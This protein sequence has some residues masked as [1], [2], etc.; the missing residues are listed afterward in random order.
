M[1]RPRLRLGFRRLTVALVAGARLVSLATCASASARAPVQVSP[2]LAQDDDFCLGCHGPATH[3]KDAPLTDRGP[4]RDS[5]HAAVKCSECHTSVTT[6]PHR[7]SLPPV[8]CTRCHSGNTKQASLKAQAGKEA[9]LDAHSEVTQSG[10]KGL[11]ACVNCH[12]THDVHAVSEVGSHVGRRHIASTCGTCH[13]QEAR[14]YRDSVHGSKALADNP[15][16]PTCVTCHPEHARL[17]RKGVFQEGVMKM[18]GSCHE[19]AVLQEKYAFAGDRLASYLG[20]YHGVATQLGYKRTANCASCHGSHLILPTRD[21]RSATNP[22]NLPRTCGQCHPK[23]NDN[24]TRGKIH[25]MAH[26]ESGGLLY[27]INVT[28]KWFTLCIIGMLVGHIALELFGRMRG[29]AGG[30][31]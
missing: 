15:D 26:S 6:L 2:A 10:V 28:F 16:V 5:A 30:L 31:A 22:A 1:S 4:L 14:E 11:P 13:Q 17:G 20:S 7:A 18:C 24:V 3:A 21:P 12:G 29:R 27:R 23:A 25:V 19:S 8:D 9:P